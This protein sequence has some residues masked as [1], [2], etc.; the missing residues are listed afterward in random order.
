MQDWIPGPERFHMPWAT[1]ACA[2]HLQKAVRPRAHALQQEK[3][4]QREAHA[5]QLESSPRSPKL[6]KSP[7]SNEDPEQPKINKYKKKKK[8]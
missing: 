8:E 5:P 4:L 7:L 1:K 6:E 2:P 3:P